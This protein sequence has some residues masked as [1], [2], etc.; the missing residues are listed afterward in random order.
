MSTARKARK[1]LLL[2]FNEIT[3]SLADRFIREGRMPNLARLR[4]EGTSAAPEAL[5]RPP[6]LDPWISWVT[7]HTGVDM[8]VHGAVVLEQDV[9]TIRAKRTWDYALDAGKSIGIFGSISAYPPRPV[10]GFMVPGPFAPGPE[11]FPK[12][13]E[14]A[15]ALNRKYTQ[16]HHKN[17]QQ[18]TL[19]SMAKMGVDLL[20]LGLS[21]ETCA[22]IA[23]Q[24][25]TE[26]VKPHMH[27]KRVSLQPY[28][29]Y[30]FFAKLYRM[31]RPDFATWHSNHAA[32]YQH[33]YW[34][35]WDDTGFAQPATA[36]EKRKFGGAMPHGY[37]VIDDLIGRFF[38]LKDDDT[39]LVVTSALGQ[40]P[41]SNDL[42]PEGKVC[43]KFKDVRQVLDIVGAKGVGDVVPVMDPQWNVRIS[44]AT[45]RA[46]V[47]D[48]LLAVRRDNAPTPDG[49][50]VDEV[51][52]IL[53]ITPRGLAKM[54]G[55][56][57]YHFPLPGG[58]TRSF[59]VDELF[60][61]YGDTPKEGMHDPTGMML[62]HGPG[63]ERGLFIDHTTDL[64]VAPT[65]LALLGIEAPDVM[66]GRALSEAWGER[67]ASSSRGAQARSSSVVSA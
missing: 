20:K 65:V 56:S 24:L 22:R 57:T 47:R 29:N 31:F 10:P 28:V 61:T 62:I 67:K 40:K 9:T 15:Q 18:D 23:L 37:M 44:D 53:T 11:T 3:W 54:D 51:G 48:A 12:F 30:D 60:R 38:A 6:Y 16:V 27:W 52:E 33:H 50:T 21:P 2:E 66:Q 8:A 32:H 63:I 5:E 36:E 64:D 46:R 34:R 25:A 4:S 26:R 49:I 17:A 7:V 59:K 43:V 39:V 45:E 14:P 13:V 35:A 41:F 58:G 19:L 1:V 42:Y 55:A